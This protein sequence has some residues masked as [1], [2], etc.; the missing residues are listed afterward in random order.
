MGLLVEVILI[1]VNNYPRIRY[2]F[3]NGI[4]LV[5]YGA[6]DYDVKTNKTEL[7]RNMDNDEY[8]RNYKRAINAL[9]RE[10]KKSDAY[11]IKY[12]WAP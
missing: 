2:Q 1:D 7:V 9:F 6:F 4:D 5:N 3:T 11:P 10:L 8:H 12:Y